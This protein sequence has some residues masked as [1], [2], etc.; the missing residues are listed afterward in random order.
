MK[1]ER[2][3]K[4]IILFLLM[5]VI[6]MT[7]GF[8]TYSGFLNIDGTVN[9]KSSKWS[10]GYV[11]NSYSETTGSAS[12]TNKSVTV[13][14]YT[15]ETTLSKPG[16]FYEATVNVENAG[17]LA[18]KVTGIEMSTLT[19]A[20]QKYLTYTVKYDNQTYSATNNSLNLALAAGATKPLVV[21]VDY[22]QP[23]NSSDL[24]Q[25]DVE[26]KVTGKITYSIDQ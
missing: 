20:Q 6:L 18:A 2:K 8:A 4:R 19:E 23:T 15:F 21:R 26:V 10:V 9:V 17:T 11:L 16:D 14:T 7:V 24:P 3:E 1:R 22:V 13:D 25:E 12:A 5:G